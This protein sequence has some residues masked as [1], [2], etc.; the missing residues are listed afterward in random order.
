MAGRDA[1]K[2]QPPVLLFQRPADLRPRLGSGNVDIGDIPKVQD[3][4]KRLPLLQALDGIPQSI[5]GAEEQWSRHIEDDDQAALAAQ[6]LLGLQGPLYERPALGPVDDLVIHRTAYAGSEQHQGQD[7]PAKNGESD[8]DEDRH[9]G[10]QRHDAGVGQIGPAAAAGQREGIEVGHRDADH[11]HDGAHHRK[12]QQGQDA[13]SPHQQREHRQGVDGARHSAARTGLVAGNSAH[14]GSRARNA[15]EAGANHVAEPLSDQFAIARMALMR[16]L[17]DRRRAEQR[18]GGADQGENHDGRRQHTEPAQ[19]GD[20]PGQRHRLG[21]RLGPGKAAVQIADQRSQRFLAEDQSQQLVQRYAD[22]KSE[23]DRGEPFGDP[24]AEL[25][26]CH[27]RQG[28]SDRSRRDFGPV[29]RDLRPAH[30]RGQA[31]YRGDLAEDDQNGDAVGETAEHRIGDVFGDLPQAENTEQHLQDADQ[32]HHDEA[33]DHRVMPV[34]ALPQ[35]GLDRDGGDQ[36]YRGAGAADLQ[37]TAPGQSRDEAADDRSVKAGQNAEAYIIRPEGRQ[38]QGP[39]RNGHRQ[40][41]YTSHQSAQRV[42]PHCGKHLHQT[43]HRIR[44]LSLTCSEDVSPQ[45]AP[46]RIAS[47]NYQLCKLKDTLALSGYRRFDERS[48]RVSGDLRRH[49]SDL[50]LSSIWYG[51]KRLKFLKSPDQERGT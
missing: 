49:P 37:F 12:G 35:H 51:V 45:R 8:I 15:A 43:V 10:H 47:L 29:P 50:Q 41:Q 21:H 1:G 16:G 34:G 33:D 22:E 40:R 48:D 13:A 17:I 25:H 32:E 7:R 31:G 2:K 39:Q 30:R 28:D 19:S 27:G 9:Q 18:F 14:G 44:A 36:G 24:R 46:L 3:D 26:H 42:T 20:R 11:D 38:R 6:D 4:D 5:D 23:N